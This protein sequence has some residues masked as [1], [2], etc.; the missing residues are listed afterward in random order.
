MAK[1]ILIQQYWDGSWE[2]RVMFDSTDKAQEYI[3]E[4]ITYEIA[5]LKKT[6]ARD[7]YAANNWAAVRRMWRIR[8]YTL[9]EPLS[10]EGED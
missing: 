8:E 5:R 2:G 6:A 4:Q 1:I 7:F 10:D 3:N 9:G